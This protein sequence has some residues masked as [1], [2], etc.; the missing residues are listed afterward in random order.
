MSRRHA[1]RILLLLAGSLT[2]SVMSTVVREIVYFAP[3]TGIYTG[4]LGAARQACETLMLFVCSIPMV[5]VLQLLATRPVDVTWRLSFL[6][7]FLV[8]LTAWPVAYVIL[9]TAWW[10]PWAGAVWAFA[11]VL[12]GALFHGIALKVV[13]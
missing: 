7:A 11:L 13:P 4:E 9:F 8:N 5:L 6:R 3:L 12:G 2:V 10:H 1:S